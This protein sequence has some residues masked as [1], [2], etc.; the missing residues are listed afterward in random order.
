VVVHVDDRL[1]FNLGA[2]GT[3]LSLGD[4]DLVSMCDDGGLGSR[5]DDGGLGLG[6]RFDDGRGGS[7]ARGDQVLLREGTHGGLTYGHLD[8]ASI[9]SSSGALDTMGACTVLVLASA[10]EADNVLTELKGATSLSSLGSELSDG[11]MAGLLGGSLNSHHAG[12]GAG[13]HLVGPNLPVIAAVLLILAVL[14]TLSAVLDLVHTPSDGNFDGLLA[15]G[16][17]ANVFG[18]SVLGERSLAVGAQGFSDAPSNH[19]GSGRNG[20]GHE[21]GALPNSTRVL[22][23]AIGMLF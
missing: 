10:A 20:L 19:T 18:A 22:G 21:L 8:G 11:G 14:S 2:N 17:T 12:L 5:F 3:G 15:D 7:W 23:A 4:S 9:N 13:D 16:D 1:L 6:S